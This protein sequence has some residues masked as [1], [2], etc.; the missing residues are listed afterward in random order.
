MIDGLASLDTDP[1]DLG[2]VGLGPTLTLVANSLRRPTAKVPFTPGSTPNIDTGGEF[3]PTADGPE[4]GRD[5]D[6]WQGKNAG[7]DDR[8]E[9][10]TS[11]NIDTN[12]EFHSMTEGP[13]P[14]QDG[15]PWQGKIAAFND[16]V[17]FATSVNIDTVDEFI[18]PLGL[19]IRVKN[20]T[21]RTRGI[22]RSLSETCRSKGTVPTSFTAGLRGLRSLG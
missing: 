12:G 4:S 10:A 13:E 21:G 8:V 3:P 18:P 20:E 11:V 1:H 19:A 22:G 15:D 6:L 9:F 14:G 7:S 2:G 17:E 16:Q 5:G